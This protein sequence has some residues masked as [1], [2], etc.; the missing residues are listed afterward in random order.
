MTFDDVRLQRTRALEQR[1]ANIR[2]SMKNAL[3]FRIDVLHAISGELGI[4]VTFLFHK[5]PLK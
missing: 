3:I 2:S 1:P 4:A 5:T